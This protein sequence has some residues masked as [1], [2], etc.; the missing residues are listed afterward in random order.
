MQTGET[1]HEQNAQ[2]IQFSVTGHL[3]DWLQHILG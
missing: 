1:Q 2:K 3:T